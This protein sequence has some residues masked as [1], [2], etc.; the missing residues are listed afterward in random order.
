MYQPLHPLTAPGMPMVGDDFVAEANLRCQGDSSITGKGKNRTLVAGEVLRD[1]VYDALYGEG[2]LQIDVSYKGDRKRRLNII[3]GHKWSRNRL[4]RAAGPEPCDVMVVGKMLGDDEQ[5]TGRNLV[6]PTGKLF[7]ETL[8][9]CNVDGIGKWYV[10]NV[11][12]CVNPD[13]AGAFKDAYVKNFLHL[14]HQELRL[15]RPKYILCMGADALKALFGKN[16]TMAK[17]D[18]RVLELDIDLRMAADDPEN[19]HQALV[20]GCVHPAYVLRQPDALGKLELA[21]ARFGKLV[22][23]QRWDRAETDIDHRIIDNEL[24]LERLYHEIRALGPG[25]IIGADAEWHGEHPQNPGAYLRTIQISWADKK[26]ACIVLRRAGGEPGFR[27]IV[28]TVGDDAALGEPSE[29]G[30]RAAVDLLRRIFKGN[31]PCG[32][33]FTADLEWFLYEGLDIR[34]DYAAPESP[35]LCRTQG[36]LDTA[37]MAHA[38]DETGD[39]ALTAQALQRTTAPRYDVPLLRWK[40]TYCREHGLKPKQLEGYGDCPNEILYPYACYDADVTRRIAVALIPQL[41]CDQFG[42]DCWTPYWIS[43]SASLAVLSMKTTGVPLDRKRVD[44]LTAQYIATKSRL[45]D[46]IRQ[47]ARWPELSLGSAFQIREL[48]FGEYY[49]GYT[50]AEGKMRRLRPRG[51][52]SLKA[53]PMITTEK[54]PRLWANLAIRERLEYLPSTNK[55]ALGMMVHYGENLPVRRIVNGKKKLVRR[56]YKEIIQKVRDYRFINQVLISVLRQPVCD[57]NGHYKTDEDGHWVY[58]AGLGGSV[59]GDGRIRTTIYQTKETGR[60]S[61]ARPPLQNISKRREPDYKRIIGKDKYQHPLRSVICAPPD[62][63][64]IPADYMGAELFAMAILSGDE[65]M[66]DHVM[67]AQVPEDDPNFY[68][69]HSSVCVMAFGYDCAPTK[70]GLA[71]IDKKHMRNIAKA[72]IFGKKFLDKI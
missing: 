44:E 25:T 55:M 54:R 38:V 49:N 11:V 1:L 15:V 35:E 17:A 68:D 34:D 63:V 58:A 72:V 6:G 30:T 23:G 43:H 29:E 53:V 47:W 45:A 36:G 40:E 56:N 16:M 62:H 64:L 60:W 57:E 52:K 48:L 59:C 20:M 50:T 18:G 4:G 32:H 70:A 21:L 8:R 71:S 33:Y 69:I 66:M 27:P 22:S 37:L 19:F 7:M 28:P 65:T 24:D 41:D 10:T 46:E 61:S 12:K 3:S 42:N 13:P 5:R 67:R 14:L 51:A 31:R 2:R 39:F 26:A 9:K